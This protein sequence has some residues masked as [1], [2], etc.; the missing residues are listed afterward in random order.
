MLLAALFSKLYRVTAAGMIALF[1]ACSVSAATVPDCEAI[2][3]RIGAAEGLPAGLLPAISRIESGRKV[4]KSVHAWPW[5]LNH[6]GKGLFFDTRDAALAYLRKTV[7]DGPR[8]IDVGCMQINNYWH[9]KQ[10]SSLEAMIDPETNVRYAVRYLKELYREKGS[11][12]AAVRHYHSPDPERGARYHRAFAAARGRIS[13]N[14]NGAEVMQ[15]AQTPS[16]SKALTGREA[17]LAGG[18]FGM[19]AY[20]APSGGADY[21]GTAATENVYAALLA[22]LDQTEV[23]GIA[24]ET[25][26]PQLAVSSTSRVLQRRWSQVEAFRAML[27]PADQPD[28]RK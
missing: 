15:V 20:I 16:A 13:P 21:V 11:W 24:F 7:A 27:A 6:A 28:Q 26:A 12:D 2:A 19:S 23:E 3:T 4:G 8:N 17:M 25:F 5:T 14:A 9:G 10:F 18:L 22:L 1:S